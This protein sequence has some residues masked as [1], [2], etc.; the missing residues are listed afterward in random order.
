MDIF[1]FQDTLRPDARPRLSQKFSGLS[2]S[3][4]DVAERLGRLQANRLILVREI[5]RVLDEQVDPATTANLRIAGGARMIWDT[6]LRLL[7]QTLTIKE[8]GS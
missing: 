5:E 3:P 8:S 2:L 1:L 7:N 4:A 6:T